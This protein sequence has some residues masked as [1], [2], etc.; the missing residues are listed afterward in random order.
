VGQEVPEAVISDTMR[1]RQILFNLVGNA[2]KFTN[3]GFV[4][5]LAKASPVP[6]ETAPDAPAAVSLLLE[7]KDSG[8]GISAEEQS[9]V[10]DPFTQQHGQSGDF[11][12]TG[13]GLTITRRLVEALGGSIEVDSRPGEGSRF[14]IRLPRVEVSSAAGTEERGEEPGRA[15]EG[16]TPGGEEAPAAARRQHRAGVGEERP[17]EEVLADY[18]FTGQDFRPSGERAEE[19]REVVSG[20][21][22]ARWQEISAAF[23]IEEWREFARETEARGEDLGLAALNRYGRLLREALE[24]FKLSRFRELA[25]LYPLVAETVEK[26]CT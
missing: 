1:M 17:P 11:G 9:R 6:G 26:H 24:S 21:L 23:F 15:G 19:A 22:Y 12:G 7:V 16:G 2:V 5:V 10:F 13:L 4:Q 8:I 25:A 18:G 20:A 14:T 3:G